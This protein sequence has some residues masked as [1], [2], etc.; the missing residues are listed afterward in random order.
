MSNRH[1]DWD[2]AY[3]DET[4][5]LAS[6]GMSIK[7]ADE[8]DALDLEDDEEV[9]EKSDEDDEEE[10]EEDGL[11]KDVPRLDDSDLYMGDDEEDV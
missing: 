9:L 4:E 7:D 8:E 2:N 6:L 5:D 3:P 11:F 1:Q 10:D